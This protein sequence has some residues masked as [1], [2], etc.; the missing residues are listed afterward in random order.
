[1]SYP[2]PHTGA[3]SY[4]CIQ[5]LGGAW[6]ASVLTMVIS[7]DG[8]PQTGAI[9]HPHS[10]PFGCSLASHLPLQPSRSH[11]GFQASGMEDIQAVSLPIYPSAFLD[12]NR[13]RLGKWACLTTET[14]CGELS[15]SM[16]CPSCSEMAS[17]SGNQHQF[18]VTSAS[19]S[20][21]WGTSVVV[22]FTCCF[23]QAAH[24]D[25]VNWGST[26]PSPSNR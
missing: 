9:N 10:L 7:V 26:F 4:E 25:H 8:Q 2:T 1:M 24:W 5:D 21:M 19:S 23:P 16:R 11:H 3:S 22:A 14:P 17:T 13:R 15:L 12:A 6:F 18:T 20:A